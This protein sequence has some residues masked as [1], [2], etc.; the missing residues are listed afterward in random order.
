MTGVQTCALPIL[1]AL[2]L[3][4]VREPV[5]V[6]RHLLDVAEDDLADARGDVDVV[7]VALELLHEVLEVHEK[8]LADRDEQL[9][10]SEEA[11]RIVLVDEF[12]RGVL[13]EEA[14]RRRK[15]LVVAW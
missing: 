8:A 9:E 15:V 10:V 1:D 4:D 12:R 2:G 6:R 11:Q 3:R 14:E 7:R 13:G 5:A